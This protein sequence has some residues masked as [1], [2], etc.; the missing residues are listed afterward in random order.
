M[1]ALVILAVLIALDLIVPRWG[2]D[3]RSSRDARDRYWWPER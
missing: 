2:V 3:S 1:G